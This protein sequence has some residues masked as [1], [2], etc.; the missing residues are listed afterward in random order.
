MLMFSS[1]WSFYME[2]LISNF[3]DV[4][5]FDVCSYV[6]SPSANC[7]TGKK[8]HI[9]EVPQFSNELTEA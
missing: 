5:C 6:F 7:Q 2:N 9:N 3:F 1:Q 4:Y 8:T